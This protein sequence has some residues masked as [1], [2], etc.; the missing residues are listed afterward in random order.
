MLEDI[1]KKW[2]GYEVS[3]LEVYSDVFH[4]G[5]GL[6][7]KESDETRNMKANPLAYWSNKT[8]KQGHY[9]IL[10][11]DTF[12]EILKELQEADFCIVNGLSYFGR[13][14]R[15]ANASKMFALIFDL[16][17]V[18]D[19]NLNNFMSGAVRAGA[20]PVPNY[21]ILSGHGVH[22][23]YVFEDPVPLYPNIK[24]Q[25][26]ELNRKDVESADEYRR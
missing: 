13:R 9:R 23:Y 22:L 3:A 17:G 7:Q 4:L 2:D 14:N 16:D 26:K 21:V 19:S 6:I 25:L 12:P 10:F 24:I 1:L 11:E 5:E 15:Q 8:E 20:Y 18:S